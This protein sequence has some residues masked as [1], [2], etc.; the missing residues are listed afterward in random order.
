MFAKLLLTIVIALSP[1]YALADVIT[2]DAFNQNPMVA[3]AHIEGL[4]TYQ[5]SAGSGWSLLNTVGNPAS[6]LVTRGIFPTDAGATVDI[7]LTGGGLFTFNSFQLACAGDPGG[8]D[9]SDACEFDAE[10]IQFIGKQ[11]GSTLFTSPSFSDSSFPP[12]FLPAT[13]S[14]TTLQFDLLQ[15]RISRAGTGR[16]ALDNLVLT[17]IPRVAEPSTML[18]LVSGLAGLTA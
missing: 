17:P 11:G 2:F 3:G 9:Q 16:Q 10:T 7:F 14:G 12:T 4:F 18:L 15:I 8:L 13:S 5:V 6:S 1:T